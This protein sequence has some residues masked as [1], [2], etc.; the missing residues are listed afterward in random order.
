MRVLAGRQRAPRRRRPR[1]RTRTRSAARA[2]RAPPPAAAGWRARCCAGSGRSARPSSSRTPGSAARW[3]TTSQPLEQRA[4]R[5]RRRGRRP[6]ARSR[7]VRARRARLA[8]LLGAPVVVVEA[9][10]A[11][12]LAAV[13]QQRLGQVRADEAGAAG[14]ERPR[15]APPPQPRPSLRRARA[16]RGT[17]R[18]NGCAARPRIA[19]ERC[20]SSA[21]GR[22]RSRRAAASSTCVHRVQVRV[23]A[24]HDVGRVG[25]EVERGR[26]EAHLVEVDD[27][28]AVARRPAAGR[29]GSRR[30]RARAPEA[31]RQVG[32]SG[33]HERVE[34]RARRLGHHRARS[35]RP[36][37][38]GVERDARAARRRSPATGARCRSRDQRAGRGGHLGRGPGRRAVDARAA[39]SAAGRARAPRTAAVG[40]G[41]SREAVTQAGQRG[42]E[43][44]AAAVCLQHV[45]A[46]RAARPAPAACS[47]AAPARRDA[48]APSA[49]GQL[50]SVARR[51]RAAAG[52]TAAT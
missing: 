20:H 18:W 39:R 31:G 23:A 12:D 9:V 19:A 7:R 43:L 33:V 21:S 42:L 49:A 29:R 40:S 13:G 45:L 14:D 16:S 1:T 51:A 4:R 28:E 47:R 46:R 26:R 10:D 11:D 2:R 15:H 44:A 50:R 48:R 35:A 25:R 32:A 17:C 3:K 34:P 52:R 24:A 5:R 37:G 38:G 27:R 8:S 22:R 30:A 36:C 41:A 6:A